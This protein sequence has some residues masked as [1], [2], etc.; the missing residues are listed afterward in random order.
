VAALCAAAPV[1]A[2]AKE[3]NNKSKIVGKWKITGGTDIKADD[4]KAMEMFKAFV[5]MEFR[6]DGSARLGVEFGD[7]DFKK[8]VEK[9]GADKTS[10]NFKY[11]LGPGDNIEIYDLPKEL[12][13]KGGPFNKDRAKCIVKIDGDKMVITDEDKKTLELKKLPG[14]KDKDK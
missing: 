5:F 9:G 6:A 7:P 4:L 8:L 1:P 13:A 2:P 11:K 14:E 10:F 3:P 12:T